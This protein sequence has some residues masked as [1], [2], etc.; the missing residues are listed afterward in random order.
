MDIRIPQLSEGVNAG[1]VVSILVKVGDRV[2]RDQT[3][4]E[5]ETDKAVAPIPS[6]EAGVVSK[7]NVKE[8]DK[9]AV[10][11]L[12]LS[13]EGSGAGSSAPAAAPAAAPASAPAYAA[14][15]TARVAAPAAPA[16]GAYQYSSPSGFPPAASPTIRR[17]AMDLGIDLTRVQGS[18][19][20]GRIS[21]GDLR[22]YVQHLQ[23]LLNGPAAHAPAVHAAPAAAPAAA[24]KVSIDFAKW[25]PVEKKALTSL[26]K[27]IGHRMQESWQT[28]PHVTQFDEADITDLL[29]LRKKLA[30]KVE[31]KGGKL[32]VTILLLKAVVKALQKHPIFNSSLDEATE[33]LVYKKYFNLGVAVDSEAG[34]IVPVLKDADKK[35]IADLSKELGDLAEKTRSRKIAPDDLKGGS[36][37]ISNLGGIGGTFFTPIINRPEVAILALGKGVLKPVVKD[38]KIV[39]RTMLPIGVSYDHRVIDGADGAR[40]IRTLVESIE[41]LTEKELGA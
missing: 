5:L 28:I 6:S 33:E 4:I 39:A 19:A 9:V 12:I 22:A 37:T 2:E 35:G 31:K 18:E 7:I 23:S 38:E 13:L 10:G 20:G 40:F 3:V 11:H 25:G 16:A 36:F 8:G 41:G 27:T 17:M 32:T 15:S 24:P 34:L 14:P 21:M 26:R 1:T 30:P 29:A